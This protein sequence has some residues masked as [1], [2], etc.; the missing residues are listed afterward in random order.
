MHGQSVHEHS[1]PLTYSL[2]YNFETC[3]SGLENHFDIIYITFLVVGFIFFWCPYLKNDTL[4]QEWAVFSDT[5]PYCRCLT[6][7]ESV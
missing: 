3:N 6:T 2:V 7:R 4:L 5:I 1:S